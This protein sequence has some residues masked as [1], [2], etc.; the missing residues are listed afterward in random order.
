MRNIVEDFIVVVFIG[1]IFITL[2]YIFSHL[3]FYFNEFERFIMLSI[4][5]GFSMLILLYILYTH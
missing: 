1:I 4:I 3:P 5:A 2:L